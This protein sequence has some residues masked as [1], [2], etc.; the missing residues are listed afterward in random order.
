MG[1]SLLLQRKP[2]LLTS[3]SLSLGNAKVIEHGLLISG[4]PEI[5]MPGGFLAHDRGGLEAWTV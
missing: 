1:G 4:E 3:H 5:P 2:I